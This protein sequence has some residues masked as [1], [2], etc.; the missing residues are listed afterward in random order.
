MRG[1]ILNRQRDANALKFLQKFRNGHHVRCFAPVIEFMR[2][3]C[4][5]F[6]QNRLQA[7]ALAKIRVAMQEAGDFLKSGK[8]VLNLLV[9][10]R[11]L[12]FYGDRT[13][14]AQPRAIHL[15]ERCGCQ[16]F[17]LE[18]GEEFGNAGAQF[19]FDNPFRLLIGERFDLILQ[20][21]KGFQ[22]RFRQQIGARGQDLAE[23]HKGGTEPFEVVRKILQSGSVCFHSTGCRLLR[24]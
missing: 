24:R 5:E 19:G 14:V 4:F 13:S 21:R 17:A 8:V 12:N 10:L 9:N 18:R 15:P 2:D 16:R 1:V 11:A 6:L 20:A 7:V 23:L 3:R 22:V